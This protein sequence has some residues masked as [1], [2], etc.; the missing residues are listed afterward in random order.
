MTSSLIF[1]LVAR[2][3]GFDTT[4]AD[5]QKSAERLAKQLEEAGKRSGRSFSVAARDIGATLEKIERDAWEAG[6]GT[7]EAFK[8]A[9]AGMRSDFEKLREAG[10][11]T[12]ASL[13]SDIGGALRDLKKKVD[14]FADHSSAKAKEAGEEM[15]SSF[16][17]A[18]GGLG[19]SFSELAGHVDGPI[20]DMLGSIEDTLSSASGGVLAAGALIG[21]ALLTG[22]TGAL[23]QQR[24]GGMVAAQIGAGTDDVARLG[25]V[26]G[27]IYADNFGESLDEVGEAITAVVQNQLIDTDATDADLAHMAESAIT[28]AQ[29]VGDSTNNIAR[30]ARQ[31]LVNDLAGSAEEAFDLIVHA[32]QEGLNVNDDLVDTIVE[33]SGQFDRLGLKGPEALGLI[34][35][36]LQGG[37]RDADYAADALKE[38]AI[39]AQD[40]TEGTARGFRQIGLDAQTMGQDIAVGGT[41]ARAALD[42]TLD[43]LRAIPDPVMRSQ[44]AVDLFG[45]K[46]EDLG[47]ALFDMDLDTAADDFGDFAGATG[48][49]SAVFAESANGWETA[50]RKISGFFAEI[51]DMSD[52]LKEIDAQMGGVMAKT[53][54]AQDLFDAT[55]DTS[56]LKELK[57]EFPQLTDEVDAY[58]KKKR[59]E[60]EATEG[61]DGA[62]KN[63][64]QTLAELIE[65][66][67]Q[68]TGDALSLFD[69]QTHLAAAWD[70]LTAGMQ[71]NGL[72]LDA[73]T[74]AGQENRDNLSGW[75]DDILN[76]AAAMETQGAGVGEVTAFIAAQREA[77]LDHVE[78][79]GGDRAAASLLL[80]QLKLI[81]GNYDAHVRADTSA[82][83]AELRGFAG[84]LKSIFGQTYT[85]AANVLATA[86]G[87]FRAEGGPVRKNEGYWVGEEGVEWFEPDQNGTIIPNDVL[88]A[89]ANRLRVQTRAPVDRSAAG[90]SRTLTHSVTFAGDTDG[91]FAGAFMKMV[92]T[93]AIRIEA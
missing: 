36:A 11:T 43:R 22:I 12:G 5:G 37:A 18:V 82:A 93:G 68:L 38:F 57:E 74:A 92:R 31:L 49:A 62:T 1:D 71:E 88:M 30:A 40:G 54:E 21:G 4:M 79:M 17:E 77:Y 44:A 73:N 45:T 70:D 46:A 50:W 90:S 26:A 66:N 10:R 78:A 15:S 28:A 48:D 59:E 9:V 89:G 25:S 47:D 7:D 61:T 34:S 19:D 58:I 14:D 56:K 2:D 53:R 86:A 81:P 76:T 91:A 13:E 67:A 42:E 39:R 52:E 60:K 6:A 27:D 80:D 75:V 8:E 65:K 35:Q 33:Y 85:V 87:A 20:G 69:S 83:R 32:S 16:G 64:I 55:G 84:L 24:V 29:V 72:T 23:E 63:Y 51:G 3:K 41:T